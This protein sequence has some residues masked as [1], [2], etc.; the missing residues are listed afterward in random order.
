MYVIFFLRKKCLCKKYVGTYIIKSLVH[1]ESEYII[2]VLTVLLSIILLT[3]KTGFHF[4]NK[5]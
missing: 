5:I 3:D 4:R 2:A 1:Q